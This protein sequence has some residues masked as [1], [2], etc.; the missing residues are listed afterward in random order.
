MLYGSNVVE[1]SIPGDSL[2][3]VAFPKG[4]S[5]EIDL[6]TQ[7]QKALKF[8]ISAIPFADMLRKGDHLL[9]LVDDITRPTP[10]DQILP[11]LLEELEVEKNNIETTILI[12]LGTHR[13]LT[14]EEIDQK[15]SHEIVAKYPVLNHEWD[16]RNALV[17]LG[18]TLNGTQ[19]KINRL[20]EEVDK[21]LGIGNI[22]PHILAGWSG[23]A[24]FSSRVSAGK[25][26]RTTST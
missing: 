12:A 18:L 21:C 1:L 24:R 10:P 14:Q 17:D 16:N 23:G 25:R 8:P 2:I 5:T 20:I 9:L 26:P 3:V 4:V 22:A 6:V 7:V 13:K 11:I 19:I 15:I